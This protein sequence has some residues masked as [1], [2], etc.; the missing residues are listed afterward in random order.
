VD[1]E[2]YV[3]AT[4]TPQLTPF[5]E[6]LTAHSAEAAQTIL[7][8]HPVDLLLADQDM[9]RVTGVQL[10]EWVRERYP[11]IIRILMTGYADVDAAV[12]AI[13]RGQVYYYLLKPWRAEELHQILFNARDKFLLERQGEAD[14]AELRRLNAELRNLNAQLDQ[15]VQERTHAVQQAN[16]ELER[17]KLE[18]EQANA[19]LERRK[20]E[21]EQ[22]ARTDYL[23]TGLLNRRAMEEIGRKE[24]KARERHPE[25]LAF[26]LIDVDFFHEVNHRYLL[27]GGDE[28]LRALARLLTRCLRE[29]DYL[30][31]VG[32]EEFLV[33]APHTDREGAQVL[34]ERIRAA[35]E[36]T[37][38]PYNGQTIRITV[39]VGFAVAE[40]TVE[41]DYDR[42]YHAAASAENKAKQAGRNRCVLHTLSKSFCQIH[43]LPPPARR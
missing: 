25:P 42:M 16:A 8:K 5:F 1:D 34:A 2:P 30:G 13:N 19:E 39:S 33:I 40:N 28:V 22:L 24:L 18:L 17:R 10:L 3:L 32:G 12:E 15:R 29:A 36:D 27:T 26:G 6:V 23:L 31:R 21:L 41:A 20:L 7:A 43:F 14:A 38:I 37:P 4:L 9:P 11:K 35:V